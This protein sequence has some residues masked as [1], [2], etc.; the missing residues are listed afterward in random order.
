MLLSGLL[1]NAYQ[2]L[3]LRLCTPPQMLVKRGGG[4]ASCSVTVR[5]ASILHAHGYRQTLTG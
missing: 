3:P 2:V 4:K 1:Y 5:Q